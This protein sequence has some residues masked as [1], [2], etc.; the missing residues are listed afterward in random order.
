MTVSPEETKSFPGDLVSVQ[1]EIDT[2]GDAVWSREDGMDMD[3]ERVSIRIC[4]TKILS[5][6]YYGVITIQHTRE[7]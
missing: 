4:D 7:N 5:S 1:C 3:S 6:I 2:E